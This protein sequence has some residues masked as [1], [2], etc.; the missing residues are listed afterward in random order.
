MI[1]QAI[2]ERL[3]ISTTSIPHVWNVLRQ[4]GN[5]SSATLLFV[6][7]EMRQDNLASAWVPALAFG[8]GLNVEGTLLR[9]TKAQ[10]MEHEHVNEK[11]Q[12]QLTDKEEQLQQTQI[13]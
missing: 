4:Y 13:D 8:P 12:N 1:V 11:E 5:M 7:D 6:L 3:G 10:Q 2:C 9:A